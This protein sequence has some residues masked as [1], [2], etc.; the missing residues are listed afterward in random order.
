MPRYRYRVKD[1]TGFVLNSLLLPMV[2]E[3]KGERE[4]S[5]ATFT[6]YFKKCY[7]RGYGSTK[8]GPL[9]QYEERQWMV[10]DQGR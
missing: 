9:T 7:S 1:R 2:G 6:I 8:E 3:R 10:E 5:E 4:I